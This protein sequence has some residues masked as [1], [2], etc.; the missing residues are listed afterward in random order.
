MHTECCSSFSGLA[1]LEVNC[2]CTQQLQMQAGSLDSME[3]YGDI[4]G[5]HV[6]VNGRSL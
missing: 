4:V 2:D 5:D 6:I 3:V 1:V